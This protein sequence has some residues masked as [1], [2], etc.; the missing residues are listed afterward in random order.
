MKFA[1]HY[2]LNQVFKNSYF[3]TYGEAYIQY[4]DRISPK[5][6]ENSFALLPFW[7]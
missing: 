1:Q 6:S 3:D 5:E 2:Q 4:V 7:V